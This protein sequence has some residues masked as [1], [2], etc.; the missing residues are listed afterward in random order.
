MTESERM[1]DSIGTTTRAIVIDG[2]AEAAALRETIAA[3]AR[4]F[5]AARGRKPTMAVVVVGE[6]AAGEV[7]ARN[8]KREA[9][10]VG[11]SVVVRGLLP[12][13]DTDE[14]RAA[15]QRLNEDDAIDSILV[16]L[17]LPKGIDEA[18]AVRA[19]APNKDVDGMHPLNLAL[20]ATG[21]PDVLPCTPHACLL[22]LRKYAAPL[23]GKRTLIVGRSAVVGRPLAH[24]LIAEDCTV[25]VAHSR[26]RDLAREC[27][28]AEILVSATAKP[29]LIR[30]SWIARGAVV[31][32]V[33][34]S[35]IEGRDGTARYVG[36][37]AFDKALDR[38][39]AITPVPGGVG[40]LT[41]SCLLWNTV[42]LAAR[43]AGLPAPRP[44][45]LVP[46]DG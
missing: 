12:D 19:V 2:K 35:R 26:T 16:Q 23:A 40:P 1:M 31:I 28:R 43:R 5:A 24:M 34:T 33:G 15:I 25:T 41:V 29:H 27:R 14:V 4:D 37:V 42:H 9:D 20:L 10:A 38:A 46:R 8:K 13:A 22:L 30:G 36:D 32:D 3:A 18:E 45:A 6:D 17:P 44:L 21:T 7:Y 11:V 39:A